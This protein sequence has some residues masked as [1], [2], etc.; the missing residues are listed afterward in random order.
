MKVGLPLPKVGE[1]ES[2]SDH[3]SMYR[4]YSL[5]SPNL[6][7]ASLMLQHLFPLKKKYL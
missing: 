2:L 3:A 5:V 6:R 4:R 7:C 1:V